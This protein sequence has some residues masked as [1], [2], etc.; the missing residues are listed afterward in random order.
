MLPHVITRTYSI[1]LKECYFSNP[2]EVYTSKTSKKT[3]SRNRIPE[4][5][6]ILLTNKAYPTK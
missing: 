4:L 3:F 6:L 5:K 2:E 1:F